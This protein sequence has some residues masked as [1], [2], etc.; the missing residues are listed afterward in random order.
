[1]PGVH[2]NANKARAKARQKPAKTQPGGTTPVV[3]VLQ[4]PGGAFRAGLQ[5][6]PSFQVPLYTLAGGFF[7][8]LVLSGRG[9]DLQFIMGYFAFWE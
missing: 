4:V 6:G 7:V 3:L 1:M 9:V 8:S 5:R 2:V